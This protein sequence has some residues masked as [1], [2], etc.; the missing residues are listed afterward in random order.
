MNQQNATQPPKAGGGFG[1]IMLIAL[2]GIAL[3]AAGGFAGSLFGNNDA[4]AAAGEATA[5]APSR[6]KPALYAS[7]QP[8]LVVNFRDSSGESHYM[9]VTLEVMAREQKVID[10]VKQHAAVVRNSLILL[11]SGTVDYAALNTREHKEQLLADALGEVRKV[12]GERGV[13]GIEA[14][15]FTSLIIQ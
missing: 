14:V 13:D 5:A 10:A 12:M 4:P 11:F 8:P 6:D 15:Y 1:K 7:L 2:G 3:V 9:Q